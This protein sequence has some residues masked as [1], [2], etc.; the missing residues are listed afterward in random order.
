MIQEAHSVVISP[1]TAAG[2]T[3][4]AAVLT[5]APWFLNGPPPSTAAWAVSCTCRHAALP[6]SCAHTCDAMANNHPMNTTEKNFCI[7]I[8][9]VLQYDFAL[10]RVTLHEHRRPLSVPR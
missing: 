3:T 9:L 7:A 4:A 5:N 8:L 1:A 10:P 6:T 2:L